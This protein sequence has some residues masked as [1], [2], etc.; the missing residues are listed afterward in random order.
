MQ[1]SEV[2]KLE[3]NAFGKCTIGIHIPIIAF[4]NYFIYDVQLRR[5]A[6]TYIQHRDNGVTRAS[7]LL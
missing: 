7:L 5:Y 6:T 2:R 3:K 1:V 4:F